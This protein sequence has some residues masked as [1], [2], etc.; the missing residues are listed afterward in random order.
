MSV[1]SILNFLHVFSQLKRYLW[2]IGCC[3]ISLPWNPDP[4]Y[5]T[6]NCHCLIC[7]EILATS[8]KYELQPSS[9]FSAHSSSIQTNWN[10]ARAWPRYFNRLR[11]PFYDSCSTIPFSR[12]FYSR[13][14]F[15]SPAW[16]V[17]QAG[18]KLLPWCGN[19][20][21]WPVSTKVVLETYFTCLWLDIP[22]SHY[23]D[24]QTFTL[25]NC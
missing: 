4:Q 15:F 1:C 19:G 2:S 9:N 13:H 12:N 3:S 22:V 18:R 20:G 8:N 21:K 24:G 23:A 6:L 10:P 16:G 11:Q 14:F 17:W 7:P 25:T 5:S